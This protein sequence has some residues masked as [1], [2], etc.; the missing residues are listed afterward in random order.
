MTTTDIAASYKRQ[1]VASRASLPGARQRWLS[2]LRDDAI[3]RFALR[4]LPTQR[5][6]DWKYTSLTPFAKTQFNLATAA[7]A[8]IDGERIERFLLRGVP[9]H[10]L[11]FIDGRYDAKLSQLGTMPAG[12]AIRSLAAILDEGG[13]VL[14]EHFPSVGVGRDQAFAALNTAFMADG[15]FIRV[16]RGVCVEEPIHLLF[17]TSGASATATQPRIFVIAEAGCALTLLQ[18]YADIGTDETSSLTNAVTEISAAPGAIVRDYKLQREGTGAFHIATTA[19]RLGSDA[20]YD[21][22]A[23]AVGARLCRNE[24]HAVLDGGGI[25]CRL[26]G[27]HLLRGRQH[28]DTTTVIDHVRA[29]SRSEENY[30]CVLDD[31]ARSVFQGRIIVRPD[32]QKTDARQMNRNLLLSRQ[33]QADSKPELRIEADDVKCSHGATI[34]ELDANSVFYL[35]TRGIDEKA[36]RNL[37]IEG[38]IGELVDEVHVG[39][40]QV[41]LRQAMWS[42]LS[43]SRGYT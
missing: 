41:H 26:N 13:D 20:V 7:T 30:K 14:S 11:V 23:L 16:G 3:E 31:A 29:G 35:R 10:Q 24:I 38:F 8:R 12:L 25:G 2:D 39:S 15:A 1:F 27:A 19:V 34:G 4:G 37:L 9:H 43:R 17:V 32:A 6:E 40:V 18:T 5:L 42:W 33:A 28:T 36:A 21:S 22:F